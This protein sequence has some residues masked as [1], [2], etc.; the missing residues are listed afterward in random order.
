MQTNSS[1]KRTVED[2]YWEAHDDSDLSRDENV[3]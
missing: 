1:E 2:G 3:H